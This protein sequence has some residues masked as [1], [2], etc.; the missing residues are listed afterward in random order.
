M[1]DSY[2]VHCRHEDVAQHRPYQEAERHEDG[3]L[4]PGDP[5]AGLEHCHDAWQESGAADQVVFTSG[6]IQ[7]SNILA[8]M[9]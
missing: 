7:T 2:R 9:R 3:K 1:V 6:P 8:A 5:V 4:L